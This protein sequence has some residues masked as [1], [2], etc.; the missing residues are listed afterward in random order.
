LPFHSSQI[1]TRQNDCDVF[2]LTRTPFVIYLLSLANQSHGY[3][4]GWPTM[5]HQNSNLMN[6]Q[7]W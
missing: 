7:L 6:R 5:N 2:H 4:N 3:K 1:K